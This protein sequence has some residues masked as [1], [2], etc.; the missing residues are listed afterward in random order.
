MCFVSLA[1][2]GQSLLL[3]FWF[4]GL[5]RNAA[6]L[7]QAGAFKNNSCV[8]GGVHRLWEKLQQ[9]LLAQRGSPGWASLILSLTSRVSM[10]LFCSCSRCLTDYITTNKPCPEAW[11]PAHAHR[12]PPPRDPSQM[13]CSNV[14]LNDER[15]LGVSQPWDIRAWLNWVVVI[16]G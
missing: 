14:F 6:T 9:V 1:S 12:M 11:P 10:E 7:G 5:C 13:A 3:R 16:L 4:G 2:R 15:T 8:N